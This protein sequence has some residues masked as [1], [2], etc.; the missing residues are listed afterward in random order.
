MYRDSHVHHS[1]KCSDLRKIL[2]SN[3]HPLCLQVGRF[4]SNDNNKLADVCL[5]MT[6]LYLSEL[7]YFVIRFTWQVIITHRIIGQ[8][9]I[10]LKP[11]NE[12]KCC[13]AKHLKCT[14][15]NKLPKPRI[16]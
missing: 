8:H 1:E 14:F 4:I 3:R 5:H 16:Y 2:M 13:S 6:H 10:R 15:V 9:P 11:K 12:E 7:N